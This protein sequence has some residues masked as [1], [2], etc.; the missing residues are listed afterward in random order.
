MPGA[1]G[2]D[3]GVWMAIGCWSAMIAYLTCLAQRGCQYAG[4]ESAGPGN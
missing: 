3:L 4:A 1:P 2:I